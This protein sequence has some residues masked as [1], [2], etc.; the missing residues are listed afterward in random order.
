ML[1]TQLV[2]NKLD[3]TVEESLR[4]GVSIDKNKIKTIEDNRKKIQV[5]TEELQSERNNI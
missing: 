5:E 3:T 2:R 4:R 1:D